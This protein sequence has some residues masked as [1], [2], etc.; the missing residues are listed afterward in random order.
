M[1]PISL[2]VPYLLST[3]PA[4]SYLI[5]GLLAL[6]LFLILYFAARIHFRQRPSAKDEPFDSGLD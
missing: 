3:V 5:R 1:N 4:S 6:F 2:A